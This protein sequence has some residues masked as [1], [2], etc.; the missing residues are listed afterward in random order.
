MTSVA[1]S[2]AP[3]PSEGRPPDWAQLRPNRHDGAPTGRFARLAAT[4]KRFMGRI[5]HPIGLVLGTLAMIPA[6]VVVAV[7]WA[8]QRIVGFDP[9]DAPAGRNSR[10]VFREG[11]DPVPRQAYSGTQPDDPG[12]AIRVAH[13]L[14]ATMASFALV[15]G[16][17]TAVDRVAFSTTGSGSAAGPGP[18]PSARERSCV[19]ADAPAMSGQQGWTQLSCD[20]TAFATKANFDAVS[21]YTLADHASS[22]VN[23]RDGV[24]R[25][26]Q[27]PACTCRRVRVW[28]FGG[29]AGWGWG[30]RD[31]FTLPSQ[32]AKDAWAHGLALEISN[33]A[34]PGW[35]LGQQ[36]RRFAQLTMTQTGASAGA[37]TANAPTPPDLAVF[38]GGVD[39]L[40]RQRVRNQQGRGADESQTSNAEV[41][42]DDVLANG[43]FAWGR[44][45]PERESLWPTGTR[46]SVDR[47]G[48]HSMMRYGRDVKL[49]TMYAKASGTAPVF[50]WQPTALDAPSDAVPPS[51]INSAD[52]STWTT[53]LGAGRIERPTGVV[54]LSGVFDG[55]RRPVFVD[56]QHTNEYGAQRIAA[57]IRAAVPELS[58]SPSDGTSNG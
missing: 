47:L 5:G 23:E 19:D 29:S 35:T 56:L 7:V 31:E 30:Q 4:N 11:A 34:M 36:A 41:E 1:G 2:D 37:S 13:R 53:L 54:D 18:A 58:D 44:E 6:S 38:Y 45:H 10:W 26:W 43:P 55:V 48:H 32:L 14:A 8:G 24:R 15:I 40:D 9:L 52:R 39:D 16:V 20:M 49:A 46:V 25:T 42:I 17:V 28:W 33:Y 12:G 3:G 50:L 51:A 22:T 21:V 27:P 57:A